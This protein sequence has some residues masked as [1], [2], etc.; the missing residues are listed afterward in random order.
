MVLQDLNG[1]NVPLKRSHLERHQGLE[2][3][4]FLRGLDMDLCLID[5][6]RTDVSLPAIKV[7]LETIFRD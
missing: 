2:E 3:A 6:V 5:L 7:I 4:T 1:P